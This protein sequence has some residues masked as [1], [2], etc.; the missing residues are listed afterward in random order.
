ME[1]RTLS[2]AFQ[3]DIDNLDKTSTRA[4]ETIL[5]KNA[6]SGCVKSQNRLIQSHLGHIIKYA[7]SYNVSNIPLNDIVSEATLGFVRAISLF[8]TECEGKLTTFSKQWIRAFV[9][10]AIKKNHLV[11][12]SVKDRKA[13]GRS[14]NSGESTTVVGNVY[15]SLDLTSEDGKS[16]RHESFSIPEDDIERSEDEISN[17]KKFNEIISTFEVGSVQ[18]IALELHAEGKT[19]KE[20][21]EEIGVSKQRANVILNKSLE[22][23]RK[24]AVAKDITFEG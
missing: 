24:R 12:M 5:I 6:Q 9:Q 17:V 10:E 3:A 11:G 8:D 23:A 16:S 20:I 13:L 4:V 14:Y 19:N 1:N 7:K 22:I 15:E 2:T 18:R 21:G